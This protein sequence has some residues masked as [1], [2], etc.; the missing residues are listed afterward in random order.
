MRSRSSGDDTTMP[1]NREGGFDEY[2]RLILAKLEALEQRAEKLQGD[3]TDLK[4][5][6]GRLQMWSA[7]WGAL[8]GII[9]TAL[10]RKLLG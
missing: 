8:A 2:R 3:M 7:L 9:G 1:P 6:V 10:A 4:V 5:S